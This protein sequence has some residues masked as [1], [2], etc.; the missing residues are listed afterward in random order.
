MGFEKKVMKLNNI[1]SRFDCY[2][3]ILISQIDYKLHI[4]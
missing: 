2:S 1:I 3:I 4:G